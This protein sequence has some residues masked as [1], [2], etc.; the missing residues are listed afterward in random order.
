MHD[1]HDHIDAPGFTIAL[2]DRLMATA[3][4]RGERRRLQHRAATAAMALLVVLATAGIGFGQ[5]DAA[6][7]ATVILASVGDMQVVRLVYDSGAD[8]DAAQVSLSLPDNLELVG[9]PGTRDLTWS[10]RLR[11]GKNLL[12][13]PVLLTD[14]SDAAV[15]VAFA[16]ENGTKEV[17]LVIRATPTAPMGASVPSQRFTRR[18]S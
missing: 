6:L 17:R 16:S 1:A 3:I 15:K 7:D 11:K 13:L 2:G 10:T 9:Y 18:I 4:A 8:R 5:R 14:T 12:E